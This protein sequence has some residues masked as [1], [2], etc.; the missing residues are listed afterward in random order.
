MAFVAEQAGGRATDGV[1]RI[2]DLTPT[3]IHQTTPLFIGSRQALESYE[4]RVAR[5]G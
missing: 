3:S 2:L 5:R 1:D 4:R